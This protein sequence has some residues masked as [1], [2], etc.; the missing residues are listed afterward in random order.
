MG[1][2]LNADTPSAAVCDPHDLRDAINRRLRIVVRHLG[3]AL[4]A[5]ATEPDETYLG[6]A[7]DHADLA[8]RCQVLDARQK[9]YEHALRA[10]LWNYL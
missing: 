2:A 9:A 1:T 6:A 8:L 5:S 3:S 10:G 7:R 4:R